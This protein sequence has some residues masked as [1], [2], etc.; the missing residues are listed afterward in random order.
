DPRLLQDLVPAAVDPFTRRLRRIGAGARP[1]AAVMRAARDI[2]LRRPGR[3]IRHCHGT[4]PVASQSFARLRRLHAGHGARRGC[5]EP[6][7]A[8][9]PT[10][11]VLKRPERE[12][13]KAGQLP[14]TA[15]TA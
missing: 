7:S 12:T 6:R 1:V 13:R 3:P 10:W 4:L 9:R 14:A 2:L 15:R 8:L 5:P 11:P